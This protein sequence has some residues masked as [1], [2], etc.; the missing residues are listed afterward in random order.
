[1]G[2]IDMQAKFADTGDS[3]FL[4]RVAVPGLIISFGQ[5]QLRQTRSP[6]CFHR[7]RSIVLA[8][9]ETMLQAFVMDL[10]RVCMSNLQY[11]HILNWDHHY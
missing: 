3:I 6:F 10:P 11:H 8:R 1:V 9:C 4:K 2:C 7:T 5:H